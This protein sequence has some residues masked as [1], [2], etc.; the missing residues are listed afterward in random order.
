MDKV[1]QKYVPKSLSKNDAKIIKA[2][3]RKSRK[4]YNENK[5]YQRRKVNSYKS[6]KSG[7][8]KKLKS[9]YKQGDEPLTLKNIAR[10][11]K[12]KVAG[13]KRIIR[14]GKGAYYSSGSRPNQS[15]FTWGRARL[16]SALAG[17]PAARIDL[18]ILKESC[19]SRSKSL[20]LA[21]KVKAMTSKRRKVRL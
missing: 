3:L 21:K 8:I 18:H 14:K 4:L 7:W 19:H 2:E 10:M 11:T 15:A 13:L 20:R 9:M 6:R 16:Y 17:G 5:F 12:C 1:P